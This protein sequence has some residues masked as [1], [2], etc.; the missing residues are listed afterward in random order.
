MPLGSRG[1]RSRLGAG[2]TEALPEAEARGRGFPTRKP[3]KYSLQR[4]RLAWLQGRR[5]RGVLPA[6]L[7]R[8][9]ARGT[10]VLPPSGPRQRSPSIR[11]A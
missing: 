10:L 2:R 9:S 11:H 1:P 7:P 5:Q 8:G 6:A 4:F 3:G